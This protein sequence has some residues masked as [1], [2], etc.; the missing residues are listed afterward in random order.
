MYVCLCSVSPVALCSH[1]RVTLSVSQTTRV[2]I[3]L[4]VLFFSPLF[5]FFLSLL[6]WADIC[7]AELATWGVGPDVYTPSK[8]KIVP[9]NVR[10]H[11]LHRFLK[12]TSCFWGAAL[13]LTLSSTA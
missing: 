5:L 3:L 1:G 6:A 7:V 2:R 9:R 8:G 12:R 13:P 11:Q 10:L 4:N